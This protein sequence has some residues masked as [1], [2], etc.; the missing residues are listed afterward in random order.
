MTVVAAS[1]QQ[2][3]SSIVTGKLL[4]LPFEL[5]GFLELYC[6]WF[7]LAIMN[8]FFLRQK[9]GFIKKSFIKKANQSMIPFLTFLKSI[10]IPY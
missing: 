1:R 3:P 6:A 4:F 2:Q 9:E 10:I 8:S 7:S 5:L